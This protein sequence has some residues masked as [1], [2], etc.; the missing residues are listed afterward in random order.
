LQRA[1]F[2]PRTQRGPA[3]SAPVRPIVH[4]N[5]AC[6]GPFSTATALAGPPP[7]A[8]RTQRG[9]ANSAPVFFCARAFALRKGER[10]PRGAK[11]KIG[12]CGG[13]G[14]GVHF[15]LYGGTSRILERYFP[16]AKLPNSNPFFTAPRGAATPVAYTRS[17]Q[18]KPL[19]PSR[20]PL[21]R[22]LHFWGNLVWPRGL[23]R[24]SARQA[25]ARARLRRLGRKPKIGACGG[26]GVGVHFI[27]YGG[28]SRILERYFPMRAQNSGRFRGGRKKPVVHPPGAGGFWGVPGGERKKRGI[29]IPRA[30][31]CPTRPQNL[32]FC[33]ME[34]GN[35][36]S[37]D[38]E[39]GYPEFGIRRF[40]IR[41]SGFGNAE[42]GFRQFVI[43]QFGIR[44]QSRIPNSRISEFR[45]S[46]FGSAGFRGSR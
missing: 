34:I 6:K 4:I 36:G 2:A 27:L 23:C 41:K 16:M 14:V 15:I 42:L 25:V 28:T 1:F 20:P 31:G 10:G 32:G 22:P 17:S 19:L 21:P 18:R 24:A 7:F 8:P 5:G 13:L 37:S 44:N 11:S 35:P 9:P 33:D 30:R 46:E 26:L 40:R 29:G 38:S 12:A 39:F 3:N 43:R 45:I